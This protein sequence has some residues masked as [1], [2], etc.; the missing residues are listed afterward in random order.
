MKPRC[1]SSHVERIVTGILHPSEI[2]CAA[3]FEFEQFRITAVAKT[4]IS[5][6]S[7]AMLYEDEH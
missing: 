6:Q 5:S 7:N 2:A 1:A 4:W 3:S